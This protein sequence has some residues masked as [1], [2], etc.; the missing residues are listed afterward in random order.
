MIR[1]LSAAAL[2]LLVACGESPAPQASADPYAGLTPEIQAWRTQLEAAH[3]A[4]ADKVEGKGCEA[5]E[6]TCKG[7]KDLSAADRAGG[8][9]AKVV[10][11]MVFQ[12]R[13]GAGGGKP[14]SAFAEFAKTGGQ[15]TR[16][17]SPPVNLTT[18]AP[19]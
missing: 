12:G 1:P 18:C 6:V 17:E 7:A 14:G 5:F 15:W 9:S 13:G 11:A 3:A 4:C 10:V 19:A 8:T 16:T 2:L